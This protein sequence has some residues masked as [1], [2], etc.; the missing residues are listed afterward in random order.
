VINESW[1][2]IMNGIWKAITVL[3]IVGFVSP[4]A[5]AERVLRLTLQ[6][7]ITNVLGQNVSEFKKIVERETGGNIKVQIYPS[8]KLY[9]GKDVPK[10]VATG[11]IEMGVVP[12][13]QFGS[14]KPA[15]LLLSLPFLFTSNEAVASATRSG[16]PVRDSLDRE[17]L[18]T[19]ARP[20][21]WQ[22]FGLAIML[23][24]DKA[25]LHPDSFKGKKIRVSG[26]LSPAFVSAVGG[27]PIL[28]SGSKQ[29]DA[30]KRGIVDFAMT[31]VTSVKSRKLYTAMNHLV[32][33]KHFAA[34]F[35]VV[36]NDGV[37]RG[38][39]TSERQI[40]TKAA[41]KVEGDLRKSYGKIHRETL[42]WI[43]ANTKMT[44]SNP[45]AAE[46]AAWRKAAKPV[47]DDYVKRAGPLGKRLLDEAR[48]LK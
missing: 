15:V 25:P 24:K 13:A 30:Y 31:G 5:S 44:I 33:S 20:L 17:L 3:A 12:V 37:W 46:L 10:A 35:V 11:A 2:E 7:P 34:E 4:S 22:P 40:I 45:G 21:W 38:L 27:Q 39:S 14:A 6:L 9:Q 48:K 8:A 32:D 41:V 36:I 19:G 23:G 26:G 28:V 16:H 47:Y 18:A 43:A 1:E 29:F 42:A